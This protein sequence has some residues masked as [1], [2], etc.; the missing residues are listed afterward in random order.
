PG[1]VLV[2]DE[3]DPA[4]GVS[5]GDRRDLPGLLVVR[6]LPRVWGLAGLGAGY[7]LGDPATIGVLRDAQ[8]P[9]PV[10]GLA[11][12]AVEACSQ[13]DAVAWACRHAECRPAAA[14]TQEAAAPGTVTL[15]GAGPGG[16]DLITMRGWRALHAADVVIADRLADP[17]LTSQLR[18]G[19]RLI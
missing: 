17:G 12:A 6:G 10:S 16:P 11:L 19:V 8:P 13:P 18:P 3:A 9:C 5:L 1:R 14:A 7:L 2:V 4:E 15:I